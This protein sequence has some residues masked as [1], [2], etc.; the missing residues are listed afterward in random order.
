MAGSCFNALMMPG[1]PGA[2]APVMRVV[3]MLGLMVYLFKGLLGCPVLKKVSISVCTT[4]F[5]TPADFVRVCSTRG[6][7]MGLCCYDHPHHFKYLS[8]LHTSLDAAHA[9]LTAGEFGLHVQTMGLTFVLG[10]G[11]YLLFHLGFFQPKK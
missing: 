7:V 1:P 4:F 2:P 8:P 5:L 9:G 11:L 6:R 10:Q 3:F